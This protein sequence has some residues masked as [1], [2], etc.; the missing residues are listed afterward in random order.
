M[1]KIIRHTQNSRTYNCIQMLKILFTRGTVKIK[2]LA[3]ELQTNPRNIPEYK[4]ELEFA[5][6]QIDTVPGRNGGYR[7]STSDFFPTVR[8]TDA[9][10]RRWWS[11][12]NI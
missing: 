7:L 12:L 8:L 11:P 1:D 5:G 6:Y 4:M 3:A 10:K 9:E 2:D